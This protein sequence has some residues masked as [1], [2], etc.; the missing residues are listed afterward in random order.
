MKRL[1]IFLAVIITISV[2]QVSCKKDELKKID[3]DVCYSCV[4][5]AVLHDPQGVLVVDQADTSISN[6]CNKSLNDLNAQN[7]KSI[8]DTR[9]SW[10]SSFPPGYDIKVTGE[11]FED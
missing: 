4:V 5:R 9:G 11:C 7:N 6:E 8:E 3:P 2:L 10:Q 1:N